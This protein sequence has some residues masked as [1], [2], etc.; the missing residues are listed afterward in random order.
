MEIIT[1]YYSRVT[2]AP[3][4]AALGCAVGASIPGLP[5]CRRAFITSAIASTPVTMA[6][7]IWFFSSVVN[8]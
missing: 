3:S 6:R 5:W 8:P 1:G 7:R 4:A 2:L